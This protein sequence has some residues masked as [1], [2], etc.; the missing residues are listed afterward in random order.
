MKIGHDFKEKHSIKYEFLYISNKKATIR[1]V[2]TAIKTGKKSLPSTDQQ[3]NADSFKKDTG[4]H[5]SVAAFLILSSYRSLRRSRRLR[6][7]P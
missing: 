3:L 2:S 4:L 6:T 5:Y 7:A 1:A